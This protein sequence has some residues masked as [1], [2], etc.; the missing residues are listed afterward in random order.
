M[1]HVRLL[2][3][4]AVIAALGVT[5]VVGP[6]LAPAAFAQPAPPPLPANATVAGSGLVNPRGFTFA[7]DGALIVA[8]S[9]AIPAGFQAPG[10]PPD[11][12]FR[13]GTTTTGRV[14][15]VDLATGERSTL[16][17][18]LPSTATS[19]GDTLGPANVAFLG[20]DLY[21]LICAGPVHGWPHYPSGVYQVNP[22][23]SVRPVANLDAF[24][25]RN[26]VAF[27]PPDDEISNPYDMV[28][29]DGALWVTDGNR[30][31][32]YKVTP[33]G[34]IS[35]VADLS[36][37]HPVTTGIAAAPG[38][39]LIVVELTP[40]PY[41]E[42]AGRIHR[43][44]ADGRVETMATGTTT[45]TGV[46]VGGD[47]TVYVVEHSVSLGRPPFI[48]PFTGRVARLSGAGTLATVA[49]NLMFPTIART[50]SDGALYV[51]HFSVGADNG[52]GQIVRIDPNA[53]P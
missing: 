35:R 51:A 10:G 13:P 47:G 7:P 49:G 23:G 39:G 6:G 29:A 21:V 28:A 32:V 15:R 1:R 45:A 12:H 48:E 4:L 8:E 26:P 31:Q 41:P 33:D 43:I 52:E 38:G 20:S 2:I 27:I 30:N 5:A 25:S 22:N 42:G 24:N 36:T 40:V 16:A 44:S 34:E 37:D 17:E 46:A 14:S 9:G 18:G 19:F 53:A 11:P 50:G 3:G